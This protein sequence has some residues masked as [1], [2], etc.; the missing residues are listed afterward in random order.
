MYQNREIYRRK[1]NIGDKRVIKD[2]FLI[3]ITFISDAFS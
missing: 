1:L 2:F 3:S